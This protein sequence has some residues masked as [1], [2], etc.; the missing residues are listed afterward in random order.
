MKLIFGKFEKIKISIKLLFHFFNGRDQI[1]PMYNMRPS[2]RNNNLYR[3]SEISRHFFL[4]F[5]HKDFFSL[6]QLK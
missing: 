6:E 3:Y 2:P 5:Q 1:F 4:G